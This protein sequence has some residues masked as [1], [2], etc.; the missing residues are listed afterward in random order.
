MREYVIVSTF[1]WP[2]RIW[3]SK[4]LGIAMVEAGGYTGRIR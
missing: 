2:N 1:N 4:L 3:K